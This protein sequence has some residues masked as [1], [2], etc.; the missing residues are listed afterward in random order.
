MSFLL[1]LN[2]CLPSW[3][4]SSNNYFFRGY[5]NWTLRWNGL[6]FFSCLYLP[7]IYHRL[8]YLFYASMFHLIMPGGIHQ[9][10]RGALKILS[11]QNFEPVFD[12]FVDTRQ[13]RVKKFVQNFWKCESQNGCYKKT[14]HSKF[15]EKWAFLTPPPD[16]HTCVCVWG[17]KKCLFFGKFGA[18]CF[19]VVPVLRF[20][21]L[22]YSRRIS[23]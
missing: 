2:M 3:L 9:M 4:T 6:R 11:L 5:K 13:Y 20:T 7:F 23:F 1:T 8:T 15:S 22:P 16:T 21:L 17:G 19:H 18:L 10:M 14:K 12:Y